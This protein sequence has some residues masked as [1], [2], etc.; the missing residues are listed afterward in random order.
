LAPGGARRVGGIGRGV[1]VYPRA[2]VDDGRRRMNAM[3]LLTYSYVVPKEKRTE[4]ARLLHRMRQVMMRLGCAQFEAY[5]QVG[6]QWVGGESTGRV[7]QILKFRDRAQFLAVQAAE[8]TD[9]GAQQL[10]ADFC[11]LINLPYQ[12]QAGLFADGYYGCLVAAAPTKEER[13]QAES[14]NDMAGAV[15][16]PVLIS[17]SPDASD[18]PPPIPHCD[19]SEPTDSAAVNGEPSSEPGDAATFNDENDVSDYLSDLSPSQGRPSPDDLGAIGEAEADR[20]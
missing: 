16:A 13:E 5:E 4:H 2:K 1:R 3:L 20:R 19:M 8:K 17:G 10:I 6:K 11:Q 15:A 7:V 9:P 18:V 14:A 12:Q